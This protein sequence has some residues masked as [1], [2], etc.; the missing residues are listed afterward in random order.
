MWSTSSLCKDL[1]CFWAAI[2]TVCRIDPWMI[3]EYWNKILAMM[4]WSWV[5]FQQACCIWWAIS[6]LYTP[7]VIFLFDGSIRTSHSTYAASTWVVGNAVTDMLASAVWLTLSNSVSFLTQDSVA[8]TRLMI[9]AASCSCLN[10]TS[11]ETVMIHL[12]L[13]F[14][15][16]TSCA[17]SHDPQSVSLSIAAQCLKVT[18]CCC[19]TPHL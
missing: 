8:W 12:F 19:T 11:I 5:I 2:W 17:L 4:S 1:S 10:F 6:S 15:L 3:S 14:H 9:L 13:F 18:T 7:L 16:F